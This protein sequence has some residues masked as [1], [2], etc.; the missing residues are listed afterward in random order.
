MKKSQ[1]KILAIWLFVGSAVRAVAPAPVHLA[2]NAQPDVDA[3]K[4]YGTN[5]I[6]APLSSWPLLAT[7]PGSVPEAFL[8]LAPGKMFFYVTASNYWGESLP[9]NV[10]NTPSALTNVGGVNIKPLGK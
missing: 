4:V 7:V 8:P 5:D 10:T 6:S 3:F 9:S 2:W 1:Y